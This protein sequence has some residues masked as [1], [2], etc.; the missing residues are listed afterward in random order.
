[1]CGHSQGSNL[2]WCGQGPRF[3]F[4]KCFF[5]FLLLLARGAALPAA[6]LGQLEQAIS[7]GQQG[8]GLAPG[9]ARGQESQPSHALG[10]APTTAWECSS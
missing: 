10:S 7:D 8:W 1:M 9:S 6:G 4:V 5:P 3:G 2:S